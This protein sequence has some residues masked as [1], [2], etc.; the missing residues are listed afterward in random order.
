VRVA[1][2]VADRYAG[3]LLDW[4]RL[5]CCQMAHSVV[6]GLGLA[7]PLEGVAYK[8]RRGAV[9]AMRK[10]GF[11]DLDAAVDAMGFARIAPALALPAD[12]LAFE[13]HDLTFGRALGVALSRN[14]CIAFI[15]APEHGGLKAF[16]GKTALSAFAWRVI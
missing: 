5:D 10:L 1:Q 11:E 16:I 3:Q 6:T 2:A 15:D 14:R 7:S 8:T 4:G 9:K 12:I 13:T